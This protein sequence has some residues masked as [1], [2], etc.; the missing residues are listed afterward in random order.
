MAERLDLLK[1]APRS[2]LDAGCGAGVDIGMLQQRYPG[3][4]VLGLDASCQL[5]SSAHA[6][7]RATQPPHQRLI[8]KLL[9]SR[10]TA[11][12]LACGDFAHLPLAHQTIDVI[13]SNLALHWHLQP[14]R[15][16]VEWRRVLKTDGL[17]MFSCFGP[18]TFKELR[19]VF[20]AVDNYPHTLSFADM[21]DLGD[22]LI[23]ADFTTPVV[24]ME[25][26]TVT[27]ESAEK[28][29][30]DARAF[31]GNP[32][33]DRRRGLIGRRIWQQLLSEL[34]GMRQSDGRIPLTFEVVYG[35]AFKPVASKTEAGEAIVRFAP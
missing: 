19:Q 35:H 25:I 15:V 2:L 18:D 33:P 10:N 8:G 1:I 26:I 9:P 23:R 6:Q 27:Y 3:S 22:M 31:G 12:L 14:E 13:W 28:L 29:L 7:R 11:P 4:G 30:A 34:D 20:K 21:H 17:L 5:L 16:F 24:D 32:L